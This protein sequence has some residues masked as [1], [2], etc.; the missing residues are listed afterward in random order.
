MQRRERAAIT[1][2]IG[3]IP[4]AKARGTKP[5]EGSTGLVVVLGAQDSGAARRGGGGED[6]SGCGVVSIDGFDTTYRFDRESQQLS[7]VSHPSAKG[8][9]CDGTW[10]A[11]A[12]PCS[13]ET[14]CSLREGDADVCTAAQRL[15]E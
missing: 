11:V 13:D 12:E 1:P 7:G 6:S 3:S 15:G 14:T 9:T 8:S 2:E 5:A 4:C 10:G